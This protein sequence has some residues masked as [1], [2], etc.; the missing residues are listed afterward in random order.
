M[1]EMGQCAVEVVGEERAARAAGLPARPEHEMIDHELAARPE[2]VGQRLAPARRV[3]RVGFVDLHPGQ[4]E[5][6]GIDLVAQP[7]RRLLAGKQRAARREPFI[8]RDHGA[9]K[10]RIV[11]HAASIACAAVHGCATRLDIIR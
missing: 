2:Q 1:L 7:R 10:G 4:G 3:E 8:T 6:F 5:T 9:T 11:E